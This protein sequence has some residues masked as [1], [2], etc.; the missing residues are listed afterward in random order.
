[1]TEEELL[2]MIRDFYSKF[3][4]RPP[5]LIHQLLKTLKSR[6]RLRIFMTN[7]KAGTSFGETLR[8]F[9][10]KYGNPRSS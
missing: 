10:S 8:Q 6:Y 1:M 2:E 3:V 9:T 4:M 5:F 7:L